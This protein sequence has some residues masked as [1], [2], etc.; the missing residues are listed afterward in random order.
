MLEMAGH[1]T[2]R[3]VGDGRIRIRRG[4]MGKSIYLHGGYGTEFLTNYYVFA[5][6]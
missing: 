2:Q 3:E 6:E 4:K 5:Y 1:G